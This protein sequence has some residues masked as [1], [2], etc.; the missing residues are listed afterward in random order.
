MEEELD[1][2]VV[3][4][5]QSA[6]SSTANAL[7]R[8]CTAAQNAVA[9]AAK[10]WRT[11]PTWLSSQSLTSWRGIHRPSKANWPTGSIVIKTLST[12]STARAAPARSRGASKAIVNVFHSEFHALMLVNAKDAGIAKPKQIHPII[13]QF[14]KVR[15]GVETSWT[16]SLQ[17]PSQ[18]SVLAQAQA[19]FQSE[20]ARP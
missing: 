2:S 5:S 1:P 7:R 6:W 17:S 15:Q 9:V 3:A 14:C 19:P 10:T 8:E 16:P 20:Q 13:I 11:T 18:N 12:W 4:P